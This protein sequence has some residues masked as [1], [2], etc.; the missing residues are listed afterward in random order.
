LHGSRQ[1]RR[2]GSR[3]SLR[4]QGSHKILRTGSWKAKVTNQRYVHDRALAKQTK[5]LNRSGGHR[6]AC[7][8]Y[9]RAIFHVPPRPQ[10]GAHLLRQTDRDVET[11]EFNSAIHTS[12]SINART[13]LTL[14]PHLRLCAAAAMQRCC[15]SILPRLGAVAPA[16]FKAP[17]VRRSIHD[18]AITR[19]GKPI[20]RTPG[21]GRSAQEPAR[22]AGTAFRWANML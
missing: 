14:S 1:T 11:I 21:G 22:T 18:I 9:G 16:P 15:S 6:K 2:R 4:P 10:C 12:S 13:P 5:D 19:T 20:I 17:A 3:Q 8:G 7:A